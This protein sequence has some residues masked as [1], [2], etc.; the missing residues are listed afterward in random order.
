MPIKNFGVNWDRKQAEIDGLW[1]KR[2]GENPVYIGDQIG[3]YTL[4]RGGDV[5]YVGKSGTGPGAAITK[6][7][8]CHTAN[9]KHDKWDTF[10]WFGFR[11]IRTTGS[12]VETPRVHMDTGE[13]I[14]D[15]ETVLIFLLA[16][17]FNLRAGKYRHMVEYRQCPS[18]TVHAYKKTMG[19]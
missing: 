2:R 19:W 5:I 1:G 3:I 9:N 12:F 13:V 14:A 8:A 16:P 6:R 18:T 11:P 10:S 7:L 15:I 17:R 4:Q